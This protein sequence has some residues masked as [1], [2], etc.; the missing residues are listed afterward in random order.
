ME[1]TTKLEF[2]DFMH[3]HPSM[4][5]EQCWVQDRF[6]R[7]VTVELSTLQKW[8]STYAE[9][10][11]AYAKLQK[12][13]RESDNT[14]AKRSAANPDIV[15]YGKFPTIEKYML[16]ARRDRRE[17]HRDTS[18]EWFQREARN[19]IADPD[20][21]ATLELT[22]FEE[23]NIDKFDASAGWVRRIIVRFVIG[24]LTG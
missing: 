11:P 22:P 6:K 10:T 20:R 4:T 19:L 14:K 23:D 18:M 17:R 24:S 15:K 16:D 8:R 21:M 3:A 7:K 9:A 13:V 2:I 1:Q 12:A 5:A